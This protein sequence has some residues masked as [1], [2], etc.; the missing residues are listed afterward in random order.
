VRVP[1]LGGVPRAAPAPYQPA[2]PQGTLRRVGEQPAVVNITGLKKSGKTTTAAALVGELTR[3]GIRVGAVKTARDDIRTVDPEG[4]D[5]RRFA[6][7]GAACVLAL[8]AGETHYFERRKSR[9]SVREAVRLLPPG[10][11]VLVCEGTVDPDME[12]LTVVCLAG[13]AELEETLRVRGLH[14]EQVLAIAGPG[15]SLR[16]AGSAAGAIPR[17]D[18]SGPA[19]AAALADLVLSRITLQPG[20][21]GK[22]KH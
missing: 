2:R 22:E 16:Y 18:V 6:E 7:A 21:A 13:P 10:I 14:T 17:L 4:T 11:Q 12:R 15:A 1:A 9:S 5:T 8:L 20:V 19:G 3:R